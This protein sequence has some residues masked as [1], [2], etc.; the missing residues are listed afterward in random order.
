MMTTHAYPIVNDY[1]VKT[2][3]IHNYDYHE[4]PRRDTGSV[5]AERLFSDVKQDVKKI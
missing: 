3:C 1:R 4:R 5:I 2:A